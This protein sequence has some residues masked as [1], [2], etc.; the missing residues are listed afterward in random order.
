MHTHIIYIIYTTT[1]LPTP[2]CSLFLTKILDALAACFT[3]L[4]IPQSPA[5]AIEKELKTRMHKVRVWWRVLYCGRSPA[6]A[7]LRSLHHTRTDQLS[8]ISA[9]TSLFRFSFYTPP[10]PLSWQGP[11]FPQLSHVSLPVCLSLSQFQSLFLAK[12]AS[13][14]PRTHA[15]IILISFIFWYTSWLVSILH[16]LH[17]HIACKQ[18]SQNPIISRCAWFV[19]SETVFLWLWISHMK[20]VFQTAQTYLEN[21]HLLVVCAAKARITILQ[22]HTWCLV[23]GDLNKP[24]T[25]SIQLS[26]II[27]SI[28]DVNLISSHV[29]V[30]YRCAV[31]LNNRMWY[32]QII[33]QAGNTLKT[34]SITLN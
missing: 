5:L 32:F 17:I 13:H 24:L 19:V 28:T 23:L 8:L 1:S 7:L 22:V 26:C 3:L 10:A 4:S 14:D 34:H 11:T 15:Y 2:Q 20:T 18:S 9:N 25:L 30:E 29:F 27:H 12:L 16:I 33:K 21:Y 31:L 6:L